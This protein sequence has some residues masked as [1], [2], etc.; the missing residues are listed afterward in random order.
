[1]LGEGR[2]ITVDPGN[3][4]QLTKAIQH[5]AQSPSLYKSMS[6]CASKW[7]QQ[8]PRDGL[9]EELRSLMIEA[10]KLDNNTLAGFSQHED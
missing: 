6:V 8:S 1:M 5:V 4:A 2:G 3:S 10:W 7:S 9:R